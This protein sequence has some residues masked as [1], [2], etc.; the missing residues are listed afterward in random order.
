MKL[1][2]T[3]NKM[4]FPKDEHIALARRL[5]QNKVIYTTRVSDEYDKYI[6][7]A[8]YITNIPEDDEV[9]YQVKVIEIKSYTDI[10]QHPFYNE[11]TEEQRSSIAEYPRYQILTLRKI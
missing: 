6:L 3:L 5:S 10:K 7:N 1:S 4:T 11:L 9:T 8:L 2:N